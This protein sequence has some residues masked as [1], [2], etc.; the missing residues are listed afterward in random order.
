MSTSP[1][2][3]NALGRSLG[4]MTIRTQATIQR[5]AKKLVES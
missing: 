1:L 2:D 3:L 4:T 5:I